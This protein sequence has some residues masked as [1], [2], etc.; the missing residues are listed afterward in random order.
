[1]IDRHRRAAQG[2]RG[3]RPPPSQAYPA[4]VR[5]GAPTRRVVWHDRVPLEETA[6]VAVFQSPVDGTS[7]CLLHGL[8]T[9]NQLMGMV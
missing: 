7:R 6:S 9:I 8:A 4:I 1:M 5:N 3:I 2:A